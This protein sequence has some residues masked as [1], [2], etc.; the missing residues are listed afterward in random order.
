MNRHEI[1]GLQ[2]ERAMENR[3]SDEPALVRVRG[4]FPVEISSDPSVLFYLLGGGSAAAASVKRDRIAPN[5]RY[6]GQ[7]RSPSIISIAKNCKYENN[8]FESSTKP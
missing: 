8:E 2:S 4:L 7:G 3:L 5:F 6:E 1:R